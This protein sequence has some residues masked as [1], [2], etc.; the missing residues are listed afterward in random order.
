MPTAFSEESNLER[1]HTDLPSF[2]FKHRNALLF[3]DTVIATGKVGSGPTEFHDGKS[4]IPATLIRSLPWS[5]I[6]C[7][8]V[9]SLFITLVSYGLADLNGAGLNTF[10]DDFW[11][12]RL[13]MSPS[14]SYSLG[15]ALFV[16]LAFFIREALIRYH[17]GQVSILTIGFELR[18]LQRAILQGYPSGTW[19]D[20]DYDRIFAHLF[21]YPIALKMFLRGERDS[22][23]L[24][25]FLHPKDI[26]DLLK[27][28][29]MHIHCSLVLRAYFSAA[30]GDSSSTFDHIQIKKP[31]AGWGIRYQV[32]EILDAI[33]S[34]ANIAVRIAE[35]RPSVAYVNHLWIFLFIWMIFLPITLVSSSGWYVS[36]H[37]FPPPHLL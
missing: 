17:E 21:S 28:E 25:L 34:A 5:I 22:K 9:W 13:S 1:P 26:E 2:E 7:Q 36:K 10:D 27:S 33:D 12:S 3:L 6:L 35:F 16:L 32:I 19:H 23:Q 11:K 18:S 30:E 37:I 8:I 29:Y 20:G 24:S 4:D 31:P 14:I 15:W